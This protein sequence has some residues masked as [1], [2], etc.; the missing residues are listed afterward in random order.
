MSHA[1][2]RL[3]PAGRLVWSSGSGRVAR[4][5]MLP[6][7]W[8]SHA[9]RRGGGGVGTANRVG[10]VWSIVLRGRARIRVARPRVP[11]PGSGSRDTCPPR[12]GRPGPQAGVPAST[13][14]RVLTRHRAPLLRECD[15]ITGVRIRASRRRRSV[16]N[17]LTRGRWCTSTSRNSAASPTAAAGRFTAG[18][19]DPATSGAWATTT[20]TPRSTITPGWPTPRSTTTRKARP[21]RPSWPARPGSTPPTA[22]PSSAS[23]R[24]RQELPAIPGSS[25]TPPQN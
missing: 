17:T 1:N 11:R 8:V 3:T 4:S 21:A 10:R 19:S 2:A 23:H 20:C 25:T 16:T 6:P 7:R 24:Q 18:P 5:R 12:A 9:P 15:P 13:V 14:G 22:S